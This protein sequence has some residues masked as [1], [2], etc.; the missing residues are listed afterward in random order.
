MVPKASIPFVS[1]PEV[2]A[3]P[4][5]QPIVERVVNRPTASLLTSGGFKPF[6]HNPDKQKRYEQFLSLTDKSKFLLK[7]ASHF[8]FVF[9][10][11]NLLTKLAKNFRSKC[12]N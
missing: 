8:F 11:K 10:K 1:V 5:T 9:E 3:E 7:M 2:E 12:F 6:L 4:V